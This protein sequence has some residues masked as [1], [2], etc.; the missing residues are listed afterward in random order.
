MKII[1]P[2]LQ[3]LDNDNPKIA[4]LELGDETLDMY[5]IKNLLEDYM[6]VDA[7]EGGHHRLEHP[8]NSTH[9]LNILKTSISTFT[10]KK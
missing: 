8:R 10:L 5:E 2:A 3:E 4:Y 9:S 1:R 7:I 6:L